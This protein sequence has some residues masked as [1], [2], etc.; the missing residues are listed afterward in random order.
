MENETYTKL[1]KKVNE[2]GTRV[3][4]LEAVFEK[5]PPK[6]IKPQ[7]IRE[8]IIEK[9]PKSAVDIAAVLGYYIEVIDGRGSFDLKDIKEGF[10]LA[11]ETVP[12]NP[13]EA[14][15][16][17]VKHGYFM[18]IKTKGVTEKS[19]TRWV[20]TNTGMSFVEGLKSG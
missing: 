16:Q 8:F 9:G 17:N 12:G 2:L 15:R 19:S 14:I 18:K 6:E 4:K 3:A 13:S 10:I 7:S 11:K 1:E 20:M 5:T